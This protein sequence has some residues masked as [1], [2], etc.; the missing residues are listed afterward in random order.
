M[1]S[2]FE[3]MIL[4]ASPVEL[5]RLLYQ[6]AIA[7]VRDARGHLRNRKIAERT[8]SINMVYAVLLELTGSLQENNAPELAARL[9]GL[10]GYM[11][12]RLI[13]A[14][15]NQDDKPLAEVERLL[16][17]LAEAWRAVPDVPSQA[18]ATGLHDAPDYSS[19]IRIAV[20][21]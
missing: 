1:N 11:Q 4:S 14:N 18:S 5:I 19:A 17:T 7:S 21:A 12:A 9:K 8:A 20:S 13:E 16:T 3:Q 10:Y 6:R 15:A 2:Y